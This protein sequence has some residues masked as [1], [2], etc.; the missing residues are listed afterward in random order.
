MDDLIKKAAEFIRQKK[1]V[2]VFTGAGISAESGI[3]TYRDEQTGLW[4]NHDPMLYATSVG[5]LLQ[6]DVAWKWYLYRREE[7]GKAQPNPAHIHVAK[8]Q[9]LKPDTAIITQNVDDL[10]ERAGSENIT[11][12]HGSIYV[13]H[14]FE[15]CQGVPTVIDEL[16]DS[17]ELPPK[18][19]HCGKMLRPGV[20]WFGEV[21][22][23]LSVRAM[24]ERIAK[25]DLLLVIGLSGAITYGVPEIVKNEN[26]GIVIEINP[27]ESAITPFADVFIQEK[28][29]IAMPELIAALEKE[30]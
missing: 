12:L 29:G 27:N 7:M 20:V 28:A 18:C 4:E 24:R 26:D 10:H 25:T 16:P 5:F 9:E 15:N 21:L 2:T 1:A 11:H 14:C 23:V 3:S 8:L 17:D 13:N 22:P 6:P 30:Q 19:L